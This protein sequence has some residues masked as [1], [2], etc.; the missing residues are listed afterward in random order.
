MTFLSDDFLLSNPISKQI[1]HDYAKNLPIIDYHCH[2]EAKDIYLDRTFKTITDVWLGKDHYKWRAMRAMGYDESLVSGTDDDFKRFM[3]WARTVP[4]LIGNPLYHWTHMELKAFFGINEV[5][6]E[7]SAKRIYQKANDSLKHLTTR[8]LIKMSNVEVI[9]TTDDPVDDLRYH[10]KLK[11]DETFQTRVIPAFRPDRAVDIERETFRPWIRTLERVTE[12]EIDHLDKLER[13][14]LKRID[15]FHEHGCRLADHAID[16]FECVRAAR[17]RVEA[18]Y[19]KAYRL[20][21][22]TPEEIGIYKSHML[23]FLGRAYY[24][25][26]WVVQYHIGA[27]RNIRT[28]MY[29]RFGPDYGFDAIN[30]ELIAKRLSELLDRLDYE[31]HLPR[32]ILYTLNP[33]DF[34]VAM[35]IGQSFQGDGIPGKIQFGS[36]WWF[37]DT[38][39]GMKKQLETVANNGV[40]ALFIGML[41]DSRSFLSYPRHDYFRRILSDYIGT[42]VLSGRYPHDESMIQNMIEAICYGNAK[43]YFRFGL[44]QEGFK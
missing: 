43:A 25:R 40:L 9:C 22:L 29:E 6:N 30:D 13:A 11:D 28:R 35:T 8:A 3:A 2:L 44:D 1:Y 24:D 21:T 12:T 26:A 4:H 32:T 27:L 36:A 18:I 41:T 38:I 17:E 16:Q 31:N 19:H 34:E 15:F 33:G 20:E 7:K 23:Y 37:L 42:E 14:L 5:L 39:Q 10:E